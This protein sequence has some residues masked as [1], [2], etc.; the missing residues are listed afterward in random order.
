[1]ELQE[2][3][4]NIID[5]SPMEFPAQNNIIYSHPT[6]DKKSYRNGVIILVEKHNNNVVIIM[7]PRR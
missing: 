7:F 4:C 3:E 6:R 5:T 2:I 1:V